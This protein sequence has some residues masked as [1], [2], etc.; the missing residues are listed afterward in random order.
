MKVNSKNLP[1]ILKNHELWLSGEG[2]ERASLRFADLRGLDLS[3]ANLKNALLS[4]A[5]LRGVN[6]SDADLS[7]TD[8][9]NINASNADFSCSSL[10]GADLSFSNLRNSNLNEVNMSFSKLS[11]SDLSGS[12]LFFSNFSGSNLDLA[13]LTNVNLQGVSGNNKEI[14]SLFVTETYLI[15]YTAKELQV[16]CERHNIKEWWGFSGE[17]IK[18]MDGDKAVTFWSEWRDTIKM[19]IEKSPAKATNKEVGAIF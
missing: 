2:G 10:R 15:T 13:D 5:D 14:K 12:N 6:I 7:D 8:M 9:D 19:M 18:K 3:N 17:D 4:N 1:K 11:G 16:G